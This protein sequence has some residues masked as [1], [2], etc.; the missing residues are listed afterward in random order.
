MDLSARRQ[1]PLGDCLFDPAFVFR[2]LRRK[3]RLG[4]LRRRLLYARWLGIYLGCRNGIGR[5]FFGAVLRGC[6]SRVFAAGRLRSGVRAST[7]CASWGLRACWRRRRRMM[8]A[9]IVVDRNQLFGA[10]HDDSEQQQRRKDGAPQAFL[11]LWL[12]KRSERSGT[13]NTRRPRRTRR[14]G[15]QISLSSPRMDLVWPAASNRP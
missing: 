2:G 7:L 6:S 12:G 9:D 4:L 10:V 13:A 11:G 14:P 5:S 8:L 3:D 1:A 15:G